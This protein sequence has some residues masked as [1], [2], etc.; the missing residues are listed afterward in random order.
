[1]CHY[2][3][4]VKADVRKRMSPPYRHSVAQ[5]SAE[6]GIH[7]ATIYNSRKAWR[8]LGGVNSAS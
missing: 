2:S 4:D 5:I 8:L 1:M 6:L 3:V 7:I